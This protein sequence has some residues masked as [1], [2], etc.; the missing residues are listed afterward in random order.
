[1]PVWKESMAGKN[2]EPVIKIL[3]AI[4]YQNER[5]YGRQHPVGERFVIDFAFVH[6][7]VALEV[8]GENHKRRPQRHKDKKR[9]RYLFANNWVSIRIKNEDLFGYKMSFYKSLIKEIVE[10]RRKQY[11]TGRLYPIDFETYYDA[12]YE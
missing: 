10:D 11:E 7:Q 12:D 6:E 1:M 9:D 8:D 4:G 3:D 2:E 5:D